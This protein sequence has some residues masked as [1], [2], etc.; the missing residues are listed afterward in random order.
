MEFRTDVFDPA[1]IDILL[2]RL[3]R[4]LEAMT[5]DPGARVSSVSLLDAAERIRLGAWGNHPVLNH[6]AV[7][8][9]SI[10][11]ALAAQVAHTGSRRSDLRRALDDL[12]RT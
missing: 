3:R 9:T 5:A 10:P 11:A 12:P 1:S 7:T 8:E 6:L 2:Q 4:V